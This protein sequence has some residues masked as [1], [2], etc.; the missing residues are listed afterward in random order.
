MSGPVGDV[1]PGAG[2]VRLLARLGRRSAWIPTL[3]ERHR[4]LLALSAYLLVFATA[5]FV[6]LAFAR[7]A[8][9][10]GHADPAFYYAAARNLVSGRGFEIDYIWQFRTMPPTITHQGNDYW[11]PLTPLVMSASMGVLGPSM[12][13]ALLPGILMGL[14]LSPVVWLWSKACSPSA[15]AAFGAACLVLLEPNL[16]TASLNSDS[17]VHFA[18][19]ASVTLCV[20]TKALADARF[21]LLAAVCAAL[22]HLTRLDGFLLMPTLLGVIWTSSHSRRA[23]LTYLVLTPVLYLAVL[24]P[25]LLHNHATLGAF[26]PPASR[27]LFFVTQY[28]DLFAA[29]KEASLRTFL[30]PGLSA[31]FWR[32]VDAARRNVN[33]LWYLGG[34]LWI[35]AVAGILE[36]AIRPGRRADLRR[37]VPALL[38]LGALFAFHTLIPFDFGLTNSAFA[39]IPFLA[40]ASTDAIRR[41]LRSAPLALVVIGL[42]GAHYYARSFGM[43]GTIVNV[44]NQVGEQLAPLKTIME[45]DPGR[46]RGDEAIVM[47]RIPWEVN[48]S[49]GY[50]AVQIPHDDLATILAIAR[51]YR[52]NYLLLPA[53]REGLADIYEGT[54]RDERFQFVAEIP[55]TDPYLP[56]MDRNPSLK[57]FRLVLPP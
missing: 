4:I 3:L 9:F 19:V 43:A 28:E 48:L 32:K 27:K 18:F 17:I 42:L 51:R 44:N 30:D 53:P 38:F 34:V 25:W 10:P 22:G 54:R 1:E 6:R 7:L 33:L 40:L 24:A 39:F 21:F 29:T 31:I 37:Y 16:L 23:R 2:S 36:H 35:P 12:L 56:F 46:P 15:A 41:A 5:L 13:A 8:E 26:L 55:Y 45:R 14:A 50:R 47:T 20:M 11:P 49:T 52:V 57:L